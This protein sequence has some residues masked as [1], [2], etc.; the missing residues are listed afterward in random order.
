M[1]R[2]SPL[3]LLQCT[4]V[5]KRSIVA[6]M[7][8]THNIVLK[9]PKAL[10]RQHSEAI[11]ATD[12]KEGVFQAQL[13]LAEETTEAKVS[14]L[15]L[16]SPSPQAIPTTLQCQRG[17]VFQAQLPLAEETTEARES[18]FTAAPSPQAIPTTLQCQ[19]GKV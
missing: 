16:A 3:L 19:T 12:G 10:P 6:C 13:P 5:C 18:L 11:G 17:K 8:T 1:H 15:S 4:G 9:I 14:S 7:S 2:L